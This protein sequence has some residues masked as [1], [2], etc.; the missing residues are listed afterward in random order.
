MPLA[1]GAGDWLYLDVFFLGGSTYAIY[2]LGL[3]LLGDRYPTAQ[4]TSANVAFVMVYQVGSICGP[5][6]AG[7]AMDL[8]GP[9]GLAGIV[10]ATAVALLA[11]FLRL[12]PKLG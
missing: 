3:G 9:E 8:F 7:T 12:A 4:L 10:A 2:T 11:L 1:V 5:A 6:F